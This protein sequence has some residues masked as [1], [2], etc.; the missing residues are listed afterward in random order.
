MF[1]DH[2]TFK[3]NNKRVRWVYDRET[4]IWRRESTPQYADRYLERYL[5]WWMVLIGLVFVIFLIFANIPFTKSIRLELFDHPLLFLDWFIYVFMMILTG[6]LM[7]KFFRA[8][9]EC[10]LLS[11]LAFFTSDML[12]L[13]YDTPL[14]IYF[15]IGFA[16][17]LPFMLAALFVR[18]L[19]NRDTNNRIDE[20]EKKRHNK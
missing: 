5:L 16:V 17:S 8:L 18:F 2:Y 7:K 1:R 19:L 12:L 15:G 6:L 4:S 3:N 9:I 13:N 11:A 10:T 20:K 14:Y